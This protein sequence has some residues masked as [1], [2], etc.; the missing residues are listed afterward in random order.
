MD[1][2]QAL[3]QLNRCLI[4]S[5]PGRSLCRGHEQ[6]YVLD[7]ENGWVRRKQRL[8]RDVRKREDK[9][10]YHKTERKLLEILKLI[11]GKDNVIASVHPLWAFST[12]KVLLEYDI[13]VVSK[14]LLVEYDGIQHHE[15]P[16]FFHKTRNDWVQQVER[17]RLKDK[18]ALENGWKLLRVKYTEDVTYSNIFRKLQRE[19]YNV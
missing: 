16:N 15:Y 14:H 5:C 1:L 8:Q 10:K 11:F 18:L 3:Q 13:G 4:C 7:V 19:G 2:Y 6:L 9:R 12:K 17:D